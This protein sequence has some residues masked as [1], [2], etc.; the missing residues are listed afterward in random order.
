MGPASDL[1]VLAAFLAELRAAGAAVPADA[2][3]RYADAVMIVAGSSS[4]LYWAGR[5]TL[6]TR[7]ADHD[8]YDQVFARFW[9]QP[10]RPGATG[11]DAELADPPARTTTDAPP[12]TEP[13]P[14]PESVDAHDP[15][16]LGTPA[17][18][19]GSDAEGDALTM[20][21]DEGDDPDADQPG[22]GRDDDADPDP[23]DDE[24]PTLGWASAR[25][26]LRARDFANYSPDE[27][28]AARTL[29]AEL[30]LVPPS[31][32]GRRARPA[33]HGSGRVDLRGTIHGARHDGG[34]IMRLARTRRATTP[35]RLVL[36][37][38][39]SGSM[40]PY[41]RA[42]LQFAQVAVAGGTKVEAFAIGTRLTRLTRDLRSHDPDA[43]LRAAAAAVPDWAGGTRLGASL[44]RFNDE[45][46]IRGLAR[47]AV[48]V[49]VSD[50]WE[51]GDPQ[52]LGDELARLRRVAHRI[53][54]VNPL[55]TSVGYEPTARG[56]AAAL[57][58]LDAFVPGASIGS[59]A[60]V[61]AA[62]AHAGVAP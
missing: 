59:L 10:H 3:G 58:H 24:D 12:E 34:E 33:R 32:P 48:V 13:A 56:M 19:D 41:A 51:R 37:V 14:D 9:T 25:E 5:A 28:R 8:V 15:H 21:V 60:E 16:A 52:Q 49:I 47:G 45:W 39:I 36:L 29:M 23:K 54:W 7:R 55:K 11:D 53:V 46:G 44:R 62:V 22:D 18:P 30:R 57:P 26:I 61:A 50:G 27:L 1:E 35:R 31:R 4:G 43:A 42:L 38:D 2:L 20:G 17:G 40:A 6:L